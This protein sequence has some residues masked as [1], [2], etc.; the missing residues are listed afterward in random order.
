ME[1]VV[2]MKD[3]FEKEQKEGNLEKRFFPKR[4]WVSLRLLLMVSPKVFWAVFRVR[5][6]LIRQSSNVPLL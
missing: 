4:Y 3:E 2:L 6:M 1:F 5:R